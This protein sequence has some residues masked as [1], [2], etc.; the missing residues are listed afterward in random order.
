[1]AMP[2]GWRPNRPYPVVNLGPENPIWKNDVMTGIIN[3][4]VVETQIITN[5]RVIQNQTA[6]SLT[7]LDDV[8]VMNSHRVSESQRMGYYRMSY[9]TSKGK[10][11]G[12]VMFI[13]RGQPVIIFRQIADPTGVSRLAKTARRSLITAMKQAE[14]AEAKLKKEKETEMQNYG[15][16]HARSNKQT[17][18]P[19]VD[20]Q[21]SISVQITCI[22]CGNS[23]PDNSNFCIKCGN[24]LSST[25]SKC[26]NSNPGG[27]AFCNNCGFAL[28]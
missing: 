25:C 15:N 22:K 18:M 2:P 6:V 12:D 19:A 3:R 28:A 17:K 5:Y 21:A 11:V 4:K 13:Y 16:K 14:K 10:T 24:P 8:I 27:S 7:D 9:G 20:D 1:M 23:N 26:G